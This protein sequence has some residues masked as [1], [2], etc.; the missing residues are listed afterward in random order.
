MTIEKTKKK[1]RKE[2]RDKA[3]T[4]TH[5]SMRLSTLTTSSEEADERNIDERRVRI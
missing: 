3:H 2:I 5:V 1:G 4:F